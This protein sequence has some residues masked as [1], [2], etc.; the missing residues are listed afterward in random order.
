MID[1]NNRIGATRSKE[2]L[3]V[4]NVTL[5]SR[6]IWDLVKLPELPSSGPKEMFRSNRL[7]FGNPKNAGASAE[8]RVMVE[9][10]ENLGWAVTKDETQASLID[11]Y[12]ISLQPPYKIALIQVKSSRKGSR[13]VHIDAKH[14][15][16]DIGPVWIIAVE[17]KP[18]EYAYLIFSHGEFKKYV[19][20]NARYYGIE[21]GYKNPEWD[22]APP[23]KLE[24][25]Y[26]ESF[27]GQWSK[28]AN[29]ARLYLK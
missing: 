5:N 20:D 22:F 17:T 13:T 24:H 28:I 1:E 4:D 23:S 29:N 6:D 18:K 15:E 9:I 7:R 10:N 12:A 27:L 25:T 2:N 11:L 8:T 21:R 3:S 26:F 19:I 16:F 14:L